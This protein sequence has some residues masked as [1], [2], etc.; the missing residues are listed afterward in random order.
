M[1]TSTPA[2]LLLDVYKLAHKAQYPEDTQQIYSTWIPRAS[3]Y[4]KGI[5]EVV[6]FGIQGFIKKYLIDYYNENFFHRP[7]SEV[8]A[9]YRRFLIYSLFEENPDSSHIEALHDLG[10]LPISIR[11]LKEGTLT[12]IKVPMLTIENTND[13]FFWLTNYLETIISNSIWQPMTSATIAFQ[14]RKMFEDFAYRTVGNSDHVPYQ[15]HDFSMRGMG[16]PEASETSGAAHL[17][18]FVGTDSVPG[19][20]YHEAYYNANMENELIGTSIPATEHSVMSANSDA[21]IK[22]EFYNF[23][24]LI[25]KTYPKG[26][27]SIVSDTYD[28]W[29]VVGELLPRLKDEIMARDGKVVIRPDSGDPATILCGA[30][31]R[32][33]TNE[34][35]CETLKDATD[36]FYEELMD[37]L[38]EETPHGQHGETEVY[39]KF[40]FE[41][42]YYEIEINIEYDR[43]DKQYYYIDS[44]NLVSCE[45]YTP[46]LSDLGLIE[47]LWNT[48]GGTV[49]EL[50]YKVLDPH[51]GAIYGDSITLERAE[52]ILSR[53]EQKGFASS[54]IVLGVGSY[55]Y[56][57]NT[58]D[59]FQ[60][61]MKATYAQIQGEEKMLFKDPKTDDGTKKSLKGRV[62]VVENADNGELITID[63]LLYAEWFK[64]QRYGADL[65]EEVFVDGILLRDEKLSEIRERLE[66][67]L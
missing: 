25:T 42:K 52:D 64:F 57:H 50:G 62:V 9:E 30:N 34:K 53:L 13:N 26:Y 56:Q 10:Y 19:I 16:S 43:H 38:R 2:I 61:A 44:H 5:D 58:R 66:N 55:T 36:T 48:F 18:S 3:K 22:D 39:G 17:L 67:Q 54:N 60:F 41:D 4:I 6:C 15:L 47:C 59:T 21:V 63:N 27:V 23:E 33:L 11:A 29:K 31:I 46:A 24:K 37:I 45:E 65:L 40:K 14:Y 20:Y 35:Y 49:N 32:D 1:K 28:F 7:K 8:V 51:I 12:P